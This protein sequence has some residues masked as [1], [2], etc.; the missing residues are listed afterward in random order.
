MGMSK[1][2]SIDFSSVRSDAGSSRCEDLAP[3]VMS[4]CMSNNLSGFY[5]DPGYYGSA[6]GVAESAGGYR[7]HS[8]ASFNAHFR[9]SMPNVSLH[10]HSNE[11]AKQYPYYMLMTSNQRLPPHVDRCHL[12]VS[13]LASRRRSSSPFLSSCSRDAASRDADFA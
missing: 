9:R 11:P 3:D 8:S 2:H 13:R 4:Q 6:R 5:F 12:E 7:G 10:L 1:T